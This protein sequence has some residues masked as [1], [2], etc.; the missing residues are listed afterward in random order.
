MRLGALAILILAAAIAPA[1]WA[2][3][4]ED[5]FSTVT[6]PLIADGKPDAGDST[7]T[8]YL[9]RPPGTGPFPAVILMHGCNG[10]DWGL[11]RRPGWALLVDYAKRYVAHGYVALILDSFTPRG[12]G[13][14]CGN[15]ALVRP[16]RRAWDAFSAARWLGAQP[17]VDKDRLVLQGDSHGGSTLLVTFEAGR[18]R[19]PER[20]AAGIAFYPGCYRT[21]AG[22]TAP[23]LILIGDA[24]DWTHATDCTALAESLRRTGGPE[25]TLEIF[26]GATHA[27]D[28]PLALRTNALGHTMK[29]DAAA[30][31]ASWQA[32]DEFL[33]RH[34]K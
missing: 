34:V 11:P 8:G 16:L 7:V 10:L 20:F 6:I 23:I 1:G 17:G 32:I 19:L 30:T 21:R 24:D 28:F 2:I 22:F 33:A 31:S 29:Y 4:A 14:V 13:S 12:V 5:P 9:F 18:W 25:L 3:A 15:L 27:F 26:P